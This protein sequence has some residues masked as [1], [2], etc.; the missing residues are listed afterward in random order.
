LNSG[1]YVNIWK[2]ESAS[3]KPPLFWIGGGES[4]NIHT[5]SH[6]EIIHKKYG[7]NWEE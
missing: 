7:L 3:Q 4:L 1:D 2:E 6:E 5:V